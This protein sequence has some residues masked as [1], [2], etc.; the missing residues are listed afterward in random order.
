MIASFLS[1]L[2]LAGLVVAGASGCGG[3]G[4][5]DIATV[6]NVAANNMRYGGT[7]T[8]SIT[9][10]NLLKGVEVSIEGPCNSLTKVQAG[11]DDTQLFTC[12][13]RGL[14]EIRATI[15]SP[16]GI[17]L[18]RLTAQVP[19]PEVSVTTSKGEFVIQLDPERAPQTVLN[20]LAYVNAGFY[21]GTL[22]HNVVKDKGVLTGGFTAGLV[23]KAPTR[24]AIALE[25]N[26]G[27]KNVRGSIGMFR[28]AAVNSAQAQWYVNTADNPDLDFVDDSNPGFAVFGAIVSGLAVVDTIV[29]SETRPDLANNLA[30]VPLVEVAVTNLRQLR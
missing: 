13:V 19:A 6:N 8:I 17:F 15:S 25:S 27:L 30:G 18:A 11:S 22:F 20:F 2:V 5:G 10:R 28:G 21:N 3:S 14:G 29:A 16:S 9:G 23:A 12:D 26:K 1:R 24:A 4:G 7:S